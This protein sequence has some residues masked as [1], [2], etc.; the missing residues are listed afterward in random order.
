[1][2]T[3]APVYNQTFDILNASLI[4]RTNCVESHPYKN[5]FNIF[6]KILEFYRLGLSNEQVSKF[7]YLSSCAEKALNEARD[8]RIK[9]AYV[10]IKTFDANQKSVPAELRHI[11]NTLYYPALSFVKYASGDYEGAI[12]EVRQSLITLKRINGDGLALAMSAW[13]EQYLNTCR[14]LFAARDYNKAFSE[15]ANLIYFMVSGNYEMDESLIYSA[16]YKTLERKEIMSMVRYVTDS[17]IV[18]LCNLND[19]ESL[20]NGFNI[21]FGKLIKYFYDTNEVNNDYYYYLQSILN[22]INGPDDHFVIIFN[23][24]INCPNNESSLYLKALAIKLMIAHVKCQYS[25]ISS[26]LVDNLELFAASKLPLNGRSL[27]TFLVINTTS[28]VKAY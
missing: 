26:E 11:S 21:T 28:L 14:I 10:W 8:K 16:G 5:T 9:S 22:Y 18:K 1:M 4:S 13:F 27:D 12:N 20:T 15:S 2:E 3:L 7:T 24:A 25:E 19:I 17:I 23:K 6:D